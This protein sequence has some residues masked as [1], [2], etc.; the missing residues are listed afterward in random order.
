MQLG[1]YVLLAPIGAG[2]MGEVWKARD[3]RL[4]RVVAIKKFKGQPGER[5]KREA[6]AIAALNH[7]HICQV[8]DVGPDYLVLEYI[9][10]QRLPC[11]LALEEASRVAL[12]IIN[13][14]DSAHRKG[15]IHRDL[16]PGNIML[17]HDRRSAKLLDFGLAKLM[18][19]GG[20]DDTCTMEG[21]VVGTVA[22][23]SPEQ[24]EGKPLDERSDVFS[25]GAVFYEMLAGISAFG[26]G[27]T[28]QVLS[29]ILHDDPPPLQA[30][31]A[32]ERVVAR[33]LAK[34]P[35]ER[36]QSMAD[37]RSALERIS[38]S[39]NEAQPSVAVL[40]FSTMSADKEDE[41]FSD[42]LAEEIINA[43]AHIP[44]L[45]VTARTSSFAFRGKEQDIRKI[46]GTLAVQTILEG[47][48]R[49]VGSRIR[50]TAQ[51]ISA[52][53]GYHLWSERYDR[54]MADVFAIQDEIAE[55]IALS[56]KVTLS[57][58]PAGQGRQNPD[59][60]AYA[61][62]LKARYFLRKATPGA[63]ALG[64]DALELAIALDPD[65]APA[66]AGLA[67]Y[68]RGIAEFQNAPAREALAQ[69]R[70][71]AQQALKINPSLPEAHAELAAVAAFLDYDWA[72]A[73]RHFQLA[74][75]REPI[76]AV[77]SH[78]YGFFYLLP[79]GLIREAT[80]EL[81]RALK[82]D[83]L[84]VQ[85][86]TQ[87][88][89]C[90]W[91]A[92]RKEE[93]LRQFRQAME[94]DEN[95][96]LALFVQAI[97]HAREGRIEQSLALAERAYAIAPANPSSVGLMAGLLRRTGDVKR[98]EQLL[99]ELGDGN[100]CGAPLGFLIFHNVQLEDDKCADW[101]EK[102]IEQRDPNVLPST[103]GPNRKPLIATGRW[104]SL[105]RLLKLPE[106]AT[107]Q[108]A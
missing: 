28:A 102:A 14:I 50:V 74:M 96:W 85:C 68:F 45:N 65:F 51:L 8:Y 29:A 100:G 40:P 18:I 16:K 35:N 91:S 27:S 57:P 11:P 47:S 79:L 39:H 88:G 81:E 62:F 46:A 67:E 83:P 104:P 72:A 23:M 90:Y 37:L 84:N 10:G 31:A 41:Y 63:S 98:S 13:A 105:A 99:Q 6:R 42:G 89:V 48:V 93:A 21:A 19:N 44:G 101:A 97:F 7:P 55:A 86:A 66:H 69:A 58:R 60:A 25:F 71:A 5:F 9:D 107:G 82:Q 15:I 49:R 17:T 77:V 94:L 70:A 12:E 108:Y 20:T 106:T 64:K 38:A 56:L 59:I 54:E 52:A 76:P 2:G 34:R 53:N 61:S 30:P 75:A 33:C 78:L 32:F 92:E 26:R 87:L 22:Y 80:A 36:F 3:T 95:F 1:P 103:S 4:D 43:L 73:E 24:A